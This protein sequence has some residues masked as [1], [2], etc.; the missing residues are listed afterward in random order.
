VETHRADIGIQCD[1]EQPASVPPPATV[2]SACMSPRADPVPG[3]SVNSSRPAS[4]PPLLQQP[5][6]DPVPRPLVTGGPPVSSIALEQ[7]H[8]TVELA[9]VPRPASLPAPVAEIPQVRPG[10]TLISATPENSQDL[11]Q[12]PSQVL[13]PVG[14]PPVEA[15]PLASINP[16]PLANVPVPVPGPSTRPTLSRQTTA[17]GLLAVPP[18]TVENDPGKPALRRSPRQLSPS[19]TPSNADRKRK[20]G[21]AE[22]TGSQTKKTRR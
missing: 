11:L 16:L 2:V 21:P 6:D 14:P 1:D 15:P 7:D 17:E 9:D 10:V 5:I 19:P 18:G 3:P 13:L 22:P 4:V 12:P 20:D 8:V